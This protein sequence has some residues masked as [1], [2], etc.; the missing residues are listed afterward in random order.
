MHSDIVTRTAPSPTGYLHLG[1]AYSA[2]LAYLR[3][4]AAGGRFLLRIEDIDGTRCRPEFTEAIFEDFAWLGLHWDE[5]VRHQSQHLAEYK[6]ALD[7]LA[8]RGL[9]YPCFCSRKQIQ[10]EIAAAGHAPHGFDGVIYPGTCRRLSNAERAERIARGEPYALRL[11][12][13]AACRQ[14]GRWPLSW[15]D[16]S[17]G[18]QSV[19]PD[20]LIQ[21]FG[22]VVL[23]RKETPASY[24][25]CV[26]HDDALQ[27]VTL[28]SRGRDLFPATHLHRLLQALF[29]WP[30]PAY[31]HHP[32]LTDAS[33]ERLAKRKN[34]PAL[35]DL[36]AEGATPASVWQ[37]AGL[38]PADFT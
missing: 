38:E 34:A 18:Q 13:A 6:R 36:R 3:A 11:N 14:V 1:H 7:D 19:T 30:V 28:V 2:G 20:L 31:A 23:A 9:L 33:G 8:S 22:D 5:P 4:K 12:I 24:H 15:H 32:L 26:C 35:R 25:L 17:E 10:A 21:G 27:G 16:E 37:Q 29:G